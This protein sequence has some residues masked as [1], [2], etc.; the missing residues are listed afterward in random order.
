MT[1]EKDED[2]GAKKR[3]KWKQRALQKKGRDNARQR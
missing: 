1:E 3:N 2:E